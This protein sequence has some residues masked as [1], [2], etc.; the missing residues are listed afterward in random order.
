[1]KQRNHN[2]NLIHNNTMNILKP[3]IININKNS[4]KTKVSFTPKSIKKIS[5]KFNYVK[6]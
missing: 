1:M 5:E 6:N 3:K 4:H 2:S